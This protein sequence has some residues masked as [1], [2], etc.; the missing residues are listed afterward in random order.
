MRRLPTNQSFLKKAGPNPLTC[1]DWRGLDKGL[2]DE[3]YGENCAREGAA[4]EEPSWAHDILICNAGAN[5][6]NLSFEVQQRPSENV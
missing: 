3:A 4:E 2:K 6:V 1:R 5:F